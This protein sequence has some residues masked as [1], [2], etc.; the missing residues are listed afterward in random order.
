VKLLALAA[1]SVALAVAGVAVPAVAGPES[2]QAHSCSSRYTHAIVGGAHKCLGPGQICNRRHQSTYRRH[3]F[4]CKAGS[5]GRPRL[6]R[7]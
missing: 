2:A 1:T 3:G 7:R 5:D 4:V 6:H